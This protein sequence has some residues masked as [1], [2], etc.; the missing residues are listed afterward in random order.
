MAETAYD[1]SC[2]HTVPILQGS[3][4]ATV[5]SPWLVDDSEYEALDASF[6]TLV[7]GEEAFKAVY[8]AIEQAKK[9]V[10]IICW[11]FQPSMYFIRDGQHLMIGQLLEKI[12]REKKV[13]VRVLSWGFGELAKSNVTGFAGEAN[14]PGRW[15][16]DGLDE[17]PLGGAFY[18]SDTRTSAQSGYDREWFS[19]YDRKQKSL[20]D[21]IARRY[22]RGEA[23]VKDK[24][25]FTSRAYSPSDKVN[26]A[27]IDHLDK[28]LSTATKI[29][30]G[31]A[32]SHHQKMVVVDYEEPDKATGFVMGHNMLDAYWDTPEHSWQAQA[33]NK[34]R[35]GLQPLHDYSSRVTGPVLGD[36]MRNFA[37]P[38]QEE[39]GDALPMPSFERHSVRNADPKAICQILR[40]QPQ[41][42]REDI[43][44]CYL[45]AAANASQYIHIE[46]QYF[47]WPP[48]AEKIKA[49]AA[50]MTECGRIPE[51]HG[52][53]YLFVITNTADAGIGAGTVNTYRMLDSLGRADRLPEVAR[54]QRLGDLNAQLE[55]NDKAMAPLLKQRATLDEQA[56]LLGGRGGQSL[57]D[58]YEPINTKLA[59]LEERKQQ[60][61]SA[62][63]RLEP[64]SLKEKLMGSDRTPE[65]IQQANVPGLKVHVATL[66]APDTPKGKAWQEVYIHAKLMLIDDTFM[67]LGSANIN[68]RSMQT[69]S[70]LNIAHHRPEITRPLRE[71]QW[72]KYTAGLVEAGMALQDAHEIWKRVMN[73]NA[74]RKMD[75]LDPIAQLAE[76]LRTSADITNKD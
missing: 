19:V 18:S 65:E 24:L 71:T 29:A 20:R 49:S 40:T 14:T 67:T 43:L 7:N 33:A 61:Q 31:A 30:L 25:R 22:V 34:G 17:A 6:Q 41:D 2:K 12:A 53:L 39:T 51:K 66:V 58:R 21:E 54:D 63:T 70:E 42:K 32:P 75:G 5:T 59:P 10:C 1:T 11:G 69:D 38:W 16:G 74:N 23:A 56:R 52:W 60:L 27:K 28:G 13:T 48:L 4:S 76:F 68:T 36:L 45:K 47:R 44:K 3:M 15:N 50:R 62:K 35:N 46:N 55:Q 57:N 26:L 9:S 8:L 72:A 37:K 64:K 73:D